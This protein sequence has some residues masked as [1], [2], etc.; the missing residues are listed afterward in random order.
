MTFVVPIGAHLL[1]DLGSSLIQA[2]A[3]AK[4][5]ALPMNHEPNPATNE[6]TTRKQPSIELL[7][8]LFYHFVTQNRQLV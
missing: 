5:T 3:K 4:K 6:P 2:S 7:S 1:L 8:L